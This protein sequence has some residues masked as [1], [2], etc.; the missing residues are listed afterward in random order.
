MKRKWRTSCGTLVHSTHLPW[1]LIIFE[2]RTPTMD[3]GVAKRNNPRSPHLCDFKRKN[4]FIGL[5]RP[6]R[7]LQKRGMWFGEIDDDLSDVF[8]EI[9]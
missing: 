2:E 4:I 7:D 3:M 9:A 1:K 5:L 8:C 6:L